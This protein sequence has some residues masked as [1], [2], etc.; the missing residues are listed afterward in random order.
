MGAE[1]VLE[2]TGDGSGEDGLFGFEGGG[3]AWSWGWERIEI[4]ATTRTGQVRILCVIVKG[5]K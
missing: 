4:R 3:R 5:D 1:L 2:V